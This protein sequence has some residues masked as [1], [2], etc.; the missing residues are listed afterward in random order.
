ME[1][2]KT[3]HQRRMKHC[4]DITGRMEWDSS[5]VGVKNRAPY[6]LIKDSVRTISVLYERRKKKV[7]MF[8][9]QGS[10]F[11]PQDVQCR[12]SAKKRKHRKSFVFCPDITLIK[13]LKGRKSPKS[14]LCVQILKWHLVSQ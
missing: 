5:P 11:I 9:F 3:A 2:E 6:K 14:F 8:W 7:A 4:G 13:S 10:S 1:L 12:V